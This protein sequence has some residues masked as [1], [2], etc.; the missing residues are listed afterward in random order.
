MRSSSRGESRTETL[1]NRLDVLVRTDPDAAYRLAAEIVARERAHRVLEPA[2]EVL[3]ARPSP[4]VRPALRQ[5]FAD[6]TDNGMRY[7]QDCSLRVKIVQLLRSIGSP[8]DVDLAERGVRSIQLNPPARVDVAQALRGQCLLLLSDIAPERAPYYAVE[9][10]HDPHQSSF[11]G[12][13]A[14]TA[15]QVLAE[16]AQILPVWAVARRTGSHPDVLAQAFASLRRS[17]PDL[18]LDAL[19][20]QLQDAAAR[21]ETGE[22]VAL[23]AAEAIVLNHLA[24]GYPA[25][26]DLLRDT[27]NLNLYRYL[28]ITAA[29]DGDN[30]VREQLLDAG[31]REKNPAKASILAEVFGLGRRSR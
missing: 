14:V 10:L 18:Q 29:R 15:I 19:L 30:P 7:D 20:L 9:L 16:H 31:S 11:S 17:P 4:D 6:L 27:T 22:G 24:G 26:I 28:L 3:S 13:P 8:E 25:V 2:L 1:A 5:R 23:V 21:G 12:E